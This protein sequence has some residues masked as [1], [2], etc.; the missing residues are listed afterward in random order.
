MQYP[1]KIRII[2]GRLR[3]RVVGVLD[4]VG[5]RPTPDRVRETLFNWLQPKIVEA[6]CLDCFAGTGVLGFEALSR[7]AKNVTMI[8]SASVV[9]LALKKTM[10]DFKIDDAQCQI[11]NQ[12]VSQW[13]MKQADLKSY[14]PYDI[15]F[16]DPPFDSNLLTICLDLLDKNKLLS[17]DAWVYVEMPAQEVPEIALTGWVPFKSKIAGKVGYHLLAKK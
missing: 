16:L 12:D 7:G 2:A 1:G 9:T 8:D 5:L 17:P 11:I 10:I 3:G 14:L 15:L 13:L 4:E 6:R